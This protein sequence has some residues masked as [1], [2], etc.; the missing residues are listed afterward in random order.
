MGELD[1]AKAKAAAYDAAADYFG[2]PVSSLWRRFRRQT[3]E[4]LGLREG[5]TVLDVLRKRRIGPA[6][7]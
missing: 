3:I 5:E 2:H 1:E 4:R 6:R 7:R